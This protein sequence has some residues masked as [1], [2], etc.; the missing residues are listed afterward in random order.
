MV[1]AGEW[2]SYSYKA[3]NGTLK[4]HAKIRKLSPVPPGP[5]GGGGRDQDGAARAHVLSQNMDVS[6]RE[7]MSYLQ[8]F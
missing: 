7:K 6:D 1:P 4:R 8:R 2:P 5:A 3:P